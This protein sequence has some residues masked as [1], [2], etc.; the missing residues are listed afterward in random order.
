MRGIVVYI[1][2]ISALI[3]G[4]CGNLSALA[5]DKKDIHDEKFSLY[6]VERNSSSPVEQ[7]MLENDPPTLRSV[8]VTPKSPGPGDAITITAAIVNDP[9]KTSGKPIS[10]SLYYSRDDG[11]SWRKV[12]M[13]EAGA[14]RENW[15]GVIP[16]AGYPGTLKYFFTAE[17]DGGNMLIELPKVK[18]EWGGIRHPIFPLEVYDANDDFRM[19]PNNLDI[20]SAGVAYDGNILYFTL[21]VE[22]K[23]SSGTVTPFD[24]Y[25]YS[26]GLFYPDRLVDGSVRT[27]HVLV[28]TQ[29]G[30][31]LQFP[32]I[33]L[34][35]TD[36]QLAEIR[37]ADA[38]F[39]TDGER[40]FMRFS[41]DAL[42]N[43]KF[44]KLRIVF[45]SARAVSYSP[46]TLQPVDVSMFINVSS[47]DRSIEIK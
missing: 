44:D 34:L 26:V 16:P 29:H 9:M 24:V 31:F 5:E 3:A 27:D 8:T 46:V 15:R 36:R 10:A 23:I 12:T 43:G 4:I 33:G 40:L 6:Y 30:Q 13:E 45:G 17:D 25:V 1:V 21:R 42:K 32:V 11:E 28:H 35:N 38:R 37:S 41:A 39:Y 22:G 20:L 14:S 47:V 19:V 18:V 2:L 7:Y